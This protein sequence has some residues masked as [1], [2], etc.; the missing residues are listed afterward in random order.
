MLK[1]LLASF[2]VLLLFS[3]CGTIP[4]LPEK[5]IVEIGVIDYPRDE[6]ITN[7]TG[8]N[9]IKSIDD[10]S[11]SNV[12][13]S[14]KGVGS[15]RKPLRGYDKAVSFLPREWEKVQNYVDQLAEAAK[16]RCQ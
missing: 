12:S 3:A 2:N 4:N 16:K 8:G 1:R 10:L 11:Y 6:I 14:A 7:M 5:P 13:K 9:K 15:V